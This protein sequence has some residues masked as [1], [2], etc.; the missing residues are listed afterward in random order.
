LIALEWIVVPEGQETEQTGHKRKFAPD[1]AHRFALQDDL[2][3]QEPP[4]KRRKGER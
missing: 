1:D 4:T 2:G 3:V